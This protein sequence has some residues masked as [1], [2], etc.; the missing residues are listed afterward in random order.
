M[1]I[2]PISSK[3][4]NVLQDVASR[5]RMVFMTGLPGTGK[6]LL[7]QQLTLI[8]SDMGRQ[9]HLLQYD[10]A[11]RVFERGENLTKYPELDGVTDP[12]IR[13]A[14]GLWARGAIQRWH[15]AH[16]EPE[17]LLIGEL[18]L[19]GNRLIELI[20]VHEDATEAL[21]SSQDAL[22]VIPVPSWEVRTI[23]EER[24]A[25]TIASPQHERE[26]LDAPPN[27]LQALW[28]ELNAFAREMGLTKTNPDTPYNPYIYG[29]VYEALLRYRHQQFLLIE[30]PLK[31]KQSVYELDVVVSTLLAEPD[32]IDHI[33]E[34]LERDYTR[35]ELQE[36]VAN[37]HAI[38]SN[39]SKTVD[40]GPELRLLMPE[41]LPGLLSKSTLTEPQRAALQAIIA[42]PLNAQATEVIP[43]IEQALST[44]AGE[45]TQ[46]S[47]NV[48]KFDVYDSYFN[49]TRT[50]EEG[51]A[52][53]LCGL[54]QAYCNVIA[55][56]QRPPHPLTVIELPM[57]RIALE[58][59]LRQFI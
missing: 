15:E 16:P 38:I 27:V 41:E 10:V 37:W 33:M 7:I 47:A 1:L 58:T 49:V 34:Q 39:Q 4:Y 55:D 23:I 48:K 14:V 59:T 17:H 51:Q 50:N 3:L 44:L 21:L 2:V 43:A 18:P 42:L 54:L 6:S 5:R 29:G 22:F 53:F 20:E 52:V 24:R 56:L 19:I 25:S 46:I 28:V 13:K 45:T 30:Q 36:A 9:V 35:E 31:P 11:R 32:E 8:A 12:A 26:T 40:P 57:L